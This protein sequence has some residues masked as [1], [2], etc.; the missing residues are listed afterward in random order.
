MA[1]L[2]VQADTGAGGVHL[3][4]GQ[5][6]VSADGRLVAV[7]GDKIAAHGGGP[8]ALASM[9]EASTFVTIAG[10]GVCRAGDKASCGHVSTGLAWIEVE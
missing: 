6:F 8:H 1:G 4:S 10:K 9:V 3:A 5:T 7:L 2:A